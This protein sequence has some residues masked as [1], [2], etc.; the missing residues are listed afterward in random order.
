MGE[1]RVRGLEIEGKATIDNFD[2]TASYTY[3]DSEITKDNDGNSGNRVGYVPEH[4]ASAWLNYRF[5]GALEGLNLGAGVRYVG[6]SYGDNENTVLNGS[7]TYLDLSAGYDFGVRN[8]D[9]EGLRLDVSVLN[10]ADRKSYY[11]DGPW[12]CQWGKRLTAFGTLSYRW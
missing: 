2:L 11:C 5:D 7:A 1:I 10:A 12:G 3:L 9:L 6:S 8:P 4:T